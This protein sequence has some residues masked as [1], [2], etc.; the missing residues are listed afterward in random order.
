MKRLILLAIACFFITLLNAQHTGTY[1]NPLNVQFGDPYILR[2][3]TGKYYMYGTGA[4]AKNGFAAYSS[5]NL[6][7][8]KQE[9]QVYFGD[10][11]NGWESTLT[12]LRKYMNET[13]NTICSTAPSGK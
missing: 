6:V 1:S 7:D 4:G 9:G 2:T 5:D 10:N 12:G 13:A 11:K 3:T 8:W